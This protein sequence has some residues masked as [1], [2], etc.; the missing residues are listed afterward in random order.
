R[1]PEAGLDF[2]RAV[3]GQVRDVPVVLQSFRKENEALAIAA[4]ASFLLKGS[5]VLLHDLR[6]F[7]IEYFGFGDFIFRLPE[8]MDVGRARDM[9]ELGE[10]LAEVPAASIAYHAERNHFS[11]WLKARTEFALARRLRPERVTDFATHEALRRSLIGAIGSYRRDQ[12]RTLVVD[13]D[14][15]TFDAAG[16]FSRI[17]GGSLGGKARG[18]AFVRALLSE[19]R[20]ADRFPNVEV[21]V[22]ASV[23]LGTTVFDRFLDENSLRDFAINSVDDDELLERF[24][25]APFPRD[26]LHDLSSYLSRVK[27]PIA[28]RS[29]SLLEDSQYQPFTG[30]YDT[31]M[32]TNQGELPERLE[33]LVLAIK[34]VY[35]STFSQRAKSHLRATPYRLEE[36]KMA[37]ILQRIVGARHGERFYPDF[38]GVAR[39][40][41]FYPVPPMSAVDGIAAVAL[42]LG[43][44]VVEGERCV[45]FCPR[46]PRQVLH[47]VTDVLEASQTGFWA[48]DLTGGNDAEG[49]REM[50]FGLGVA[51]A[52]GTLAAVGST[53]SAEND[54]I[55]DGVSRT[56]VRVVSFAQVLK[57]DAFPL[58]PLLATLLKIGSDGGN[59]PVEIE[60]AV[61]LSVPRGAPAEFGF[62][63]MRQLAPSRELE[64]LDVS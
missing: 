52:D 25:S 7:M 60:F 23:V 13:F 4:G 59:A 55:Y 63:Q 8:G 24:R 28:V 42:G 12:N 44:A 26:A 35:A 54:A 22:P 51:E 5:P 58:A 38:A 46:A 19:H 14:R 45:R 40:Y 47:S 21:S 20:L 48:L 33:R 11:K 10:R 16:S 31:V 1:F 6:R 34:R 29:S 27:E 36:E 3:R 50:R 49:T 57:H 56:G 64:E 18:L 15:Q 9:K 32:L 2:A 17:G 39:S 37:V 53:F 61:N 30:V 41:N 43:K 62:L